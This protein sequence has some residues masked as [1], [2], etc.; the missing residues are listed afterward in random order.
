[1]KEGTVG[2]ESLQRKWT[3]TRS[4]AWG[5]CEICDRLQCV[6]TRSA[7]WGQR[8]GFGATRV[9]DVRLQGWAAVEAL[10]TKAGRGTG[11]VLLRSGWTDRRE[12][13]LAVGSANLHPNRLT[14][15][16]R[17][18]SAVQTFHYCQLQTTK[19]WNEHRRGAWAAEGQPPAVTS[20]R[21][22]LPPSFGRLSAEEVGFRARPRPC[23]PDRH[24]SSTSRHPPPPSLVSDPPLPARAAMKNKLQ[25]GSLLVSSQGWFDCPQKTT[26]YLASSARTRL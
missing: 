5:F 10:V 22:L 14:P 18:S 4:W 26:S 7:S 3:K 9:K 24:K 15:P 11:K 8:R 23:D 6:S 13:G 21:A 16:W 2:L 1:M 17:S 19:N 25:S 20:T 12:L